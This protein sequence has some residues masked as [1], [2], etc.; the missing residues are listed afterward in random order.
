MVTPLGLLWTYN[1]REHAKFRPVFILFC[2]S[3][4]ESKKWGRGWMIRAAD[5]EVSTQ[6]GVTS[7]RK[8]AIFSTLPTFPDE[9]SLVEGSR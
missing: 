4:A 9:S 3:K 8:G 2:D 6:A 1:H 7:A 5:G